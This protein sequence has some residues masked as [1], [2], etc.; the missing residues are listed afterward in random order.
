MNGFPNIPMTG[1]SRPHY[2]AWRT[3]QDFAGTVCRRVRAFDCELLIHPQAVD[4]V[5]A[6]R[7]D[8]SLGTP[9]AGSQGGQSEPCDLGTVAADAARYDRPNSG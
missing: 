2:L 5:T 3:F 7:A 6:S 4:G 8:I 1:L 9:D